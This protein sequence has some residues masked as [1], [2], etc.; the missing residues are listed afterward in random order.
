MAL[1][2]AF[3]RPLESQPTPNVLFSLPTFFSKGRNGRFSGPSPGSGG[4]G[5]NGAH[6]RCSMRAEKAGIYWK[7]L[8]LPLPISQP[9][10]KFSLSLKQIRED[11]RSV[12]P[13][14]E[15]IYSFEAVSKAPAAALKGFCSPDRQSSVH[16]EGNF[17]S[18]KSKRRRRR[19]SQRKW[20]DW[21]QF[22]VCP[23]LWRIEA[24]NGGFIG[25]Q[26]DFFRLR[27][28]TSAAS[29]ASDRGWGQIGPILS[30]FF[31]GSHFLDPFFPLG[32]G[33]KVSTWIGKSSS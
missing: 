17:R 16:E 10:R 31:A 21:G 14:H 26:I 15:F 13:L 11:L 19:R 12:S 8:V 24:E 4:D 7:V 20:T 33:S 2:I 27:T 22:L 25:G 5:C 29:A 23:D 28:A 6:I 9:A 3:C 30:T 18:R 1:W 32:R